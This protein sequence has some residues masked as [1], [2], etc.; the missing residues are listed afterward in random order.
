MMGGA[1][2]TPE[3][4]RDDRQ[5]GETEVDSA[6]G[7]HRT[8]FIERA[9]LDLLGATDLEDTLTRIVWLAV[10]ELADYCTI[11]LLEGQSL[12]RVAAAHVDLSEER[13]L[14]E[15]PSSDGDSD[16]RA[17]MV[18]RVLE[19][20]KAEIRR[21][22]SVRARRGDEATP[23]ER[24]RTG[25]RMHWE[26]I[27]PL[28][29]R[30]RRLGV[31]SFGV[32]PFREVFSRDTRANADALARHAA[33]AIDAAMGRTRVSAR[34]ER[35]ERVIEQARSMLDA[36]A[37]LSRA[38]MPSEIVRCVVEEGARAL[39]AHAGAVVRLVE[40]G[41]ELEV[42][43][44]MGYPDEMPA[45]CPRLSLATEAPVAE[46]VRIEQP[47]WLPSR[48]ALAA[49]YPALS[50]N[51]FVRGS[52]AWAAVP[53]VSDGEVVGGIA[54]SFPEPRT[55]DDDERW[56]VQTLA[57]H[58][59]GA[60][61]RT[62]LALSSAEEAVLL[63][64]EILRQM[65]EAI[66]VTDLS[67]VVRRWI[68]KATEIF[69]YTEAEV[70]GEPVTFLAHPDVRERLGARILRGIRDLGAFEGE[71]LC[72]RKD[73]STVPIETT[74]KPVFD[75]E[76]RPRFLVGVCRDIT[77][78]KRAEEER[79]RLIREQIARAEAEDAARRSSFLAEAGALLGASLDYAA[80]LE[81]I[82]RLAVPT[83]ADACM[84]DV[85]GEDGTIVNVSVAHADPAQ[86][87]I[88]RE[89][90]IGHAHDDWGGGPVA[91]V[92]RT[93]MPEHYTELTEAM[94]ARLVRD[95]EQ[96]T[97]LS[98]LAPRACI[99][100]A[101]AASERTLGT[102][103]LFRT[104]GR[105]STKDLALAEDLAHRAAMA[106]ENARLYRQ[107]QE[108]TRMRDE[109]LGTV[110]HELRT[111]LNAVLGWTRML[112]AGALNGASHDR[113][114]A[115]I[116]RNAILQARL[117]E[118]LLDASRIIMGKLRLELHPV[119]PIGPIRAAIE[120]VRAAATTKSIR[121]ECLLD[122]AAG[123]VDGD[124]H[125]IQ[126]I[127]W[128]LLANAIKFTPQG[129]RVDLILERVGS[130]ARISV[131]DTGEGIR[132]DFLPF[133]F[134]RFRQ[135]D[136]TTTRRHGGL[137]L[138]LAIVRHLVEMHG[139][140]VRA[141]SAGEGKGATFSVTLPLSPMTSQA[142]AQ[143]DRI[144]PLPTDLEEMPA[145]Q[146]LRLLIVDDEKDCRELLAEMLGH[147]GVVV[148]AVGSAAEALSSLDEF[149]PDMLI[150]DLGMPG[151]DGFALIRQLRAL[152]PAR[153]ASLPA[154]ALTAHA[155]AED[156]ARVL[157]AGYQMHVP[158]PVDATEIAATV[159]SL[160]PR[161][162]ASRDSS[163]PPLPA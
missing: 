151:E 110:S 78:R 146:G 90:R 118:D 53:L 70:M 55:F 41:A 72:V 163:V 111:P 33:Q 127:V 119:D 141:D 156:R 79:T 137:G 138:G 1:W 82:V 86:E 107:A 132:P 66:V 31:L 39:G 100:V 47:I 124:P 46:A 142:A 71:L 30:E 75:K 125:R 57:E 26:L 16:A 62:S 68:G 114:L 23:A 49:R 69:G 150:S 145:L 44:S 73:G 8:S 64:H 149:Q 29:T 52:H 89:L 143:P 113:A 161:P 95:P 19:S 27:L 28:R 77:E 58:C 139:G 152:K 147:W 112:R 135:G 24:A 3:R 4:V 91:R 116:E 98:R 123:L 87:R 85:T 5:T 22:P 7:G 34:L 157:A 42:V 32:G 105:Y 148:R 35:A 97:A 2:K 20:G 134:D 99:V 133:V 6:R 13:R 155:S 117:I 128:N 36:T 10:P 103:T 109:F 50:L 40:G 88:L 154:V 25:L 17:R 37:S 76:G 43:Y 126:Q 106:L 12:R 84:L 61:D 18:R 131:C 121:L 67:G 122:R 11:D 74:A 81:R 51:D 162:A 80:T 115:T 65:P 94:L 14:L 130:S 48:A 45:H 38:F 83:L 158:K 140:S 129:G 96:S 56:L 120:S 144:T 153:W 63:S 9:G 93:R 104:E 59:A 102:L 60:L 92:V 160:A 108:A 15:K 136:G 21:A 54:L 159:A 101:L